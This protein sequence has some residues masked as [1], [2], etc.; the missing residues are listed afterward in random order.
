MKK[1]TNRRF[2]EKIYS[3]QPKKNYSTNKILYNHVDEI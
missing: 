2:I 3:K 1:D